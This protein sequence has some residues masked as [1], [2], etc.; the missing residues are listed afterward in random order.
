MVDRR[1]QQTKC[2]LTRVRIAGDGAQSQSGT[3]P[4]PSGAP[5]DGCLFQCQCAVDS[6][7]CVAYKRWATLHDWSY[8]QRGLEPR[9]LR[10]R[11]CSKTKAAAT[12]PSTVTVSRRETAPPIAPKSIDID[13]LAAAILRR[14][15]ARISAIVRDARRRMRERP[16]T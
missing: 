16:Q 3:E 5:C 7:E 9:S 1:A 6:F 15:D 14:R 10:L 4:T 13:K 8:E 12:P 11:S 2:E